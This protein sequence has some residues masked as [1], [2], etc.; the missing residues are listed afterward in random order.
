M[1]AVP[2]AAIRVLS[3][4]TTEAV[5]TNKKSLDRG[6]FVQWA[7]PGAKILLRAQ[8]LGTLHATEHLITADHIERIDHKVPDGLFD[9]DR[10]DA[11]CI[12]GLAE[13]IARRCSPRVVPFTKHRA[14]PWA[15]QPRQSGSVAPPVQDETAHT[16]G[17]QS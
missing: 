5:S 12:R 3:L 1:L 8:S 14:E 7:R 15:D 13:G 6:G 16:T 11:T 10:L 9:L 4:G 17:G 2:P